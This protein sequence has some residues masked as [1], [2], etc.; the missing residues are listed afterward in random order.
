MEAALA[1]LHPSRLARWQIETADPF[2]FA[3]Q[4]FMS[5]TDQSVALAV[6]WCEKRFKRQ[7]MEWHC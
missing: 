7:V 2:Q 4:Q 5:K 3:N 1:G 6:A